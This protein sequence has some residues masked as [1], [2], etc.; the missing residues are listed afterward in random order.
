MSESSLLKKDRSLARKLLLIVL[1]LIGVLPQPWV[2]W[3]GIF[4][5]LGGVFPIY[6]GWAGWCAL[7]AMGIR[8]KI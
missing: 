8:T 4:T 3:A 6:E 2:M 5:A 1:S 7:R